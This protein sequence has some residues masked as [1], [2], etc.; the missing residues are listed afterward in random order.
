MT[1]RTNL[2]HIKNITKKIHKSKDGSAWLEL[3]AI[4]ENGHKTEITFF[5]NDLK[6]LSIIE[7]GYTH[8]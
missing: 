2:H 6:S 8:E 3:T 4:D 7:N 5:A 1:T